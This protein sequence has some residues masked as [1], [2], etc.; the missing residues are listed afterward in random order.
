MHEYW[1]KQGSEPLFPHLVW[2]RPET[3]ATAGKLLIIGGTAQS[4]AAP[5][6]SYAAAN[7]AGVGTARIILPSSLRKTVSKL[8]PEAEFAPSTPSGSFGQQAL[9]ELLPLASWADGVLIA[10]DTGSNSETTLLFES[11]LTKFPG[12]IT[13]C[14]DVIDVLTRQPEI[15]LDRAETTLVLSFAQL[16]KIA[17]VAKFP[18]AFTSDMPLLRFVAALREFAKQH[19]A[20]M[21]VT[22][23]EL[24]AVTAQGR[25]STTELVSTSVAA[26]AARTA[27]WWLQNTTKPFE[28]LTTSIII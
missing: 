11:L 16:Q 14:G 21:L 3:R 23:G 12:H 15:M 17:S 6:E 27:T 25:V 5:A 13:L 20:H 7:Q 8:F 2:A 24:T 9:G 1:Q 22:F 10:P 18:E 4:F 28:A 26:Q 19:D